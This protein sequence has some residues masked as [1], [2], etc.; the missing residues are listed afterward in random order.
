MW[1]GHTIMTFVL[2]ATICFFSL[3]GV[4]LLSSLYIAYRVYPEIGMV[5]N[6]QCKNPTPGWNGKL[7]GVQIWKNGFSSKNSSFNSYRDTSADRRLS[8][9]E[10]DFNVTDTSNSHPIVL[11]GA[12][13]KTGTFLAQKM[14]AS[15][16]A[17]MKW[18]CI[19][20]VT[21]DSIHA[22]QHTLQTEPV[23]L[24][25]H[26]QWIWLPEELGVPYKFFHFY[27]HPY[28][29]IISGYRYHKEGSES[30]CTKPL[31][32]KKACNLNSI[33]SGGV[34]A[35]D[36]R[37]RT[38]GVSEAFSRL[39]KNIRT[40]LPREEVQD[41]CKSV[42]LCEPCCRREHELLSI[43]SMEEHLNFPSHRAKKK[44]AKSN[45]F[46]TVGAH[47]EY[48]SRPPQEYNFMCKNLGNISTSLMDTLEALPLVEGL[49]VEA[50]IDY[51]ES[52]RMVQIIRHTEHD[53]NSLNID[54]DEF[55]GDF[56]GTVW[57]IM[58]TL[59]L[60]EPE[61]V[62]NAIVSDIQF[63]DVNNSPLYR[64][65][66]SNPIYNHVNQNR[67]DDQDVMMDILKNDTEISQLYRPI[68]QALGSS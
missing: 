57:K 52:L 21:R 20:H 50:A 26:T 10:Y 60:N 4:S 29:K 56:S 65:S 58:D 63:Y 41:Y 12:H 24:L 68:L 39:S 17:R 9:S 14:F 45:H 30:W 43:K 35:V 28:K 22:I 46:H 16:C 25:G 67:G 27:R 33:G 48:V 51:Y 23:H 7:R 49:R 6:S 44:K 55:M 13:H 37:N 18:C 38:V 31:F 8:T 3:V 1:N 2:L 47:R 40:P 42:H 53:P 19:Y 54:L 62:I 66:M 59:E 61:W 11:W 5:V 15:L 36:P 64:L 34:V 32:Y